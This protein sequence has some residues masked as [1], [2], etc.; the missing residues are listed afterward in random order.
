MELKVA[1][2]ATVCIVGFCVL[3]THI[4][5]LI[6]KRN[7]RKDENI[8]LWFLVFTNFHF[9]VYIVFQFLK[10]YYPSN[11]LIISFY[12]IFYIFNNLQI[13]LFY[14]YTK[15]VIP[16]PKKTRNIITIINW[17]LFTIFVGLD[18]VNIFTGMFFY[19]EDGV[20]YRTKWMVISQGYQVV[21]FTIIF[22]TAMFNKKLDKISKIA[23]NFYCSLPFVAVVIQNIFPGRA[24]AYL[25]LI[26]SFEILF[27]FVN[28]RKN[29]LIVE[30]AKKNEEAEVKIMMSQIQPHFIYN[31]LSA[32]ST[33]ITIDPE[34]AQKGLDAFT[35]YL[36]ANL[37]ALSKTDLIPFKEELKHIETFVSLEKMRFEDRLNVVYDI[38]TTDFL[39]PP[40]SIQP[41]VENAVKHG[42]LKKIKGG[43]VILKTYKNENAY[44]VEIEDDGV[45]FDMKEL[46]KDG[47]VHV[48][49]NN[50]KHRLVTMCNGDLEIHSVV[51][52]G[53]TMKITF[54]K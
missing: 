21:M 17:V 27:L 47:K 22:F 44:I 19:A 3:L 36:R 32:I 38:K 50:V 37:N 45:G 54:N 43:T 41:I 34:K 33:L 13:F 11:P 8:L 53:T 25:S 18:I 31:T 29:Y 42:V 52:Q 39:V 46:E 10:S 2:N 40:L 35:E 49:L 4:V 14:I 15:A 7:K 26:V 28:V 1:S 48:G 9:L 5:N 6:M 23:F 20:Y 51:N 16:I 24:V 12:T 30:Q